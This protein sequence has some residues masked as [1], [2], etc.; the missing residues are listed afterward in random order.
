MK[1]MHPCAPG[2]V[3]ED[4]L[5]TKS[6]EGIIRFCKKIQTSIK[7]AFALLRV[8]R[9]LLGKGTVQTQSNNIILLIIIRTSKSSLERHL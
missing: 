9:A 4:A 3:K 5:R 7:P 6:K 8:L 1:G 2:S